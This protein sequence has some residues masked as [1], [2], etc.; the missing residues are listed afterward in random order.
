LLEG[1]PM[2]DLGDTV[3]SEAVLEYKAG[4]L[5]LKPVENKK[6]WQSE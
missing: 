4:R 3:V 1:I 6:V 2:S 5:E